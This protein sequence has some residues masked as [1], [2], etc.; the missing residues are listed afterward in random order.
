MGIINLTALGKFRRKL[1]EKYV[2][3]GET[4]DDI[5]CR[6]VR[7]ALQPKGYT[8]L[9]YEVCP[10]E[11]R[12]DL[13]EIGYNFKEKT[14]PKVSYEFGGPL[15]KTLGICAD[16]LK[17]VESLRLAMQKEVDAVK[18]RENELRDHIID[19]LSVS[20]DTGAVGKKY[21]AQIKPEDKPT[22][23][24]WEEFYD[25]IFDQDRPDLLQK[26]LSEKA[27]QEMWEDGKEVPG[28][29]KFIAKKLSVTKRK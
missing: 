5:A 1:A 17:E 20:D 3:L 21:I 8:W 24:D 22:V 7:V 27:I 29:G 25:F 11:M 4:N 18:K 10:E 16:H 23:N 14:M 9:Y 15:P 12:A 28:I 26:R 2:L 13:E 6:Q 19:N